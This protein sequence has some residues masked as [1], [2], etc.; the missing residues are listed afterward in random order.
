[1]TFFADLHLHSKFSRATAGNSDLAHL[2]LWAQYKGLSVLGTGDFTH[3]QWMRELR[4]SLVP[5]EPG[6]FR[7]SSE[8]DAAVTR[9]LPRRCRARV[10]FM[11]SVEISTIYKKNDRT[12]KVHHML[13]A[14]DFE[15]ADRCRQKLSKIGNLA[16][17]GRPILGL[18]SRDLLEIVLESGPDCYLV[19]AHIWTPWFSALGSQSGFDSIDE[20]YGD[21]SQHIFA[22]ETGL[23]S[24]PPMNWRVS[25]LDRFRLVSNSDAHSPAMLGREACVF[26]AAIDYFAIRRALSQGDGYVGTVEF[27]PE[28]GKYHLD[29]HRKCNLRLTPQQTREHEKR[30]P[31]CGKPLTVGVMYRV[32]ELADRAPHEPPPTAGSVSSLVPLA[33]I[34]AEIYRVGPKSKKVTE[35]YHRLLGEL[36]P[37]LFILSSLPIEEIKKAGSELL[38]EA[39]SRLRRG[40]VIREA[41]FDGEYGRIHLFSSEELERRTCGGLLFDERPNTARMPASNPACSDE[42]ESGQTSSSRQRGSFDEAEAPSRKQTQSLS[43]PQLNG[44]GAERGGRSRSDFASVQ[45][46]GQ[47]DILVGLDV[48][49]LEAARSVTGPI[50]I[51]AGPGSGKTRTLTHRIGHLVV[52]QGVLPKQCLAIAFTRRAAQE[53]RERLSALLKHPAESFQVFTFH[54]FAFSLLKEH[55][56]SVGL[57]ADFC[58]ADQNQRVAALSRSEQISEKKARLLLQKISLLKRGVQAAEQPDLEQ[59]LLRTKREMQRANLVDFDDLIGLSVRLL[60]ENPQLQTIY[61]QRYPWISIDE[62]QDLDE[63]Q[64]RLVRLLAPPQSNLCVIGDPN[65]AIYGFRGSDVAIFHRFRHDYPNARVFS[66]TRNYRSGANIV[67]AASQIIGSSAADLLNEATSGPSSERIVIHSAATEAAEAEFVVQTIERLIGGHSFFSIDSGRSTGQS[68][69]AFSF[70]DFAVLYRIET[71]AEQVA[72]ALARS[73]IPYQK[74]SHQPL[75]ERESVEV[76]LRSLRQTASEG[77]VRRRLE[78]AAKCAIEKATDSDRAAVEREITSA[79]ELLAS[80]ADESGSN[81]SCFFSHVALGAQVDTLD[82]RA[83][84]VS[85]L[86]LHAA[87]GLEFRVVFILG[88]EKGVIPLCWGKAEPENIEEERRLF[89][90]GVTRARERLFLSRAGKRH[91]RGKIR[92]QEPSPFIMEIREELL[93]LDRDRRNR[94]SARDKGG[95]LNLF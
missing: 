6:L 58:L 27:F 21:L 42:I 90:V 23:S 54:A 30:C 26:D 59:T 50:M 37:E 82:P 14:P 24:D 31:I 5:A 81:L 79:F 83:D 2:A 68:E 11:L 7:L 92:A 61:H 60:E 69:T 62:Y 94:R 57:S 49:Q 12:R 32:M 91:L 73:G 66:L 20:C 45:T 88:C 63:Q 64:Y 55:G 28:E 35:S 41:G 1:M 80:I 95:Q 40:E 39:I 19:P 84:R 89:Y 44:S 78:A 36:G 47:T 13:Y 93:E 3:P 10:R 17:D 15:S 75:V 77:S 71:Q 8:L 43:T 56:A 16:S 9:R 76:L 51:V 72:Q 67:K 85:L 38:I 65:Q 25:S 74:R 46:S 70:S 33:E 22:V 48:Q 86:T 52:N 87:K 29:G 18:D 53:L 4:Q 34:L